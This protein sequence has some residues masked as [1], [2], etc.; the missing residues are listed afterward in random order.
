MSENDPVKKY[1]DA[2][3]E[4]AEQPKVMLMAN[5]L[6]LFGICA[7]L[8]LGLRFSNADKTIKDNV[9]TFAEGIHKTLA[10]MNPLVGQLLDAG[11]DDNLDVGMQ[12]LVN[13]C[14]LDNT[15]NYLKEFHEYLKF[16]DNGV[17]GVISRLQ[18]LEQAAHSIVELKEHKND[19]RWEQCVFTLKVVAALCREGYNIVLAGL[20]GI[21]EQI[22]EE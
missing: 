13:D 2:L 10:N 11:W 22:N 3:A 16:P 19:P 4:L 15:L 9:K 8:Q 17:D 14:Y 5:P 6:S 12:E 20:D 1:K 7:H 18:H 21:F